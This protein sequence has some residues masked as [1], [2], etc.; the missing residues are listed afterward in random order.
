MQDWL[1]KEYRRIADY[2]LVHTPVQTCDLAF[3][4]GTRHG[5]ER[6][7]ETALAHWQAGR[8][9]H[10]V[11][12]GGATGGQAATEGEELRDALVRRGM[13]PDAII[14]ERASRSS[15]EAIEN[16]LPL[17][18]ARLGLETIR[19]LMVI[20]KVSSGRRQLMSLARHWPE[21]RKVLVP[22]NCFDAALDRWFEHDEL[23]ARV[24]TEWVR[25]PAH[26]KRRDIR[27]VTVCE[28]L[29]ELRRI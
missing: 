23:R 13:P 7:A 15:L 25:I 29:P 5:V 12:T 14:C 10:I 19:S 16:A 3:V 22:V 11:V 28:P 4:F 21:P 18:E 9:R 8:F 2:V 24:F 1:A 17:I 6:F 20:T 26:L 27:E